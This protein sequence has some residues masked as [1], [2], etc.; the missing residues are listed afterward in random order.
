VSSPEQPAAPQSNTQQLAAPPLGDQ[1]SGAVPPPRRPRRSIFSGLLL[2]LLGVLFLVFHFDPELRLATLIWRFWPVVIIVWGVAKLVDHL[3]AR[4][5]GERTTV[6]TGGEAALLI[7]VVFSLA[8]LGF[9]DWLRRQTDFDFNFHPFSEKYS[10]SEALPAKKVAPGARITIQTR[11]GNISVHAGDGDELRVT[12]NKA[13]S[14]SSESA[15]DERMA[16]V[17]TTIEQTS[18]GYNVHPTNQEDW[19]GAVDADL[20]VEVPKG[21]N[22][23][24]SS[25]RGDVTVAGV[26]GAIEVKAEKG[27]IEVH[28]AG[29]DVAATLE[30]GDLRISNVAGNLRVNGRGSEIEVSDVA[31]DA[32]FDGEFFGPIRVR[33]VTKTTHYV[34]QRS[35]LTLVHMT[36][37]LELSSE[38]LEVSDVGGAAKLTTHNKD[39]EVENVAGPLGIVDSHGDIKIRY[40]RPP[41]N[42]I[43]VNND[44]GK[45][46]LTLPGNS[47]FEIS[48]ESRSGDVDSE[49]EDPSLEL[50]NDNNMGKLNGKFGSHGP[51]ITMV[52][53]Y[54]TI[55]VLKGS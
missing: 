33:N 30:K 17:K 14:G 51:K 3:A 26:R 20:D 49:F 10:Q 12:V 13:A 7:L 46:D 40:A 6:L 43:S 25:D 8:G 19:E 41:M 38:A 52:T 44:S 54:G 36:G 11:R 21:A 23:T 18:D 39:L 16:G 55:S 48:A 1:Q 32:T 29:S 15:A 24:A 42:E 2:I 28:D 35:D 50:A 31:G 34:S 5:S 37:R 47:S 45:V 9:A 27:D 22:V 4:R 53:T